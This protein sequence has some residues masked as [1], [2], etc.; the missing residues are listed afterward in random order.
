MYNLSD[1][2]LSDDENL[3]NIF[4]TLLICFLFKEK[5]F[6]CKGNISGVSCLFGVFD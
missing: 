3:K 6:Y 1:H 4:V 5:S 2:M